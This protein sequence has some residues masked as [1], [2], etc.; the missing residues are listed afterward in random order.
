MCRGVRQV[1]KREFKIELWEVSPL[2]GVP[3]SHM[4]GE[5]IMCSVVGPPLSYPPLSTT[6][7]CS[8]SSSSLRPSS[9]ITPECGGDGAE[10][11]HVSFLGYPLFIHKT[12]VGHAESFIKVLGILTGNDNEGKKKT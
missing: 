11:S 9:I 3:S 5:G 1:Q 7:E 8:R 4:F 12:T 6:L 10:M 2:E